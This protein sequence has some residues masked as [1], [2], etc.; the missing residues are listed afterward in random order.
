MKPKDLHDIE[1]RKK[2]LFLKGEK[3]ILNEL[4]CVNILNKLRIVDLLV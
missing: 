4:D 1:N 2:A 3:K